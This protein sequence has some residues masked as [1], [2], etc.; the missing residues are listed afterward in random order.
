MKKNRLFKINAII[1]LALLLPSVVFGAQS[2][3]TDIIG[4]IQGI[5]NA[6]F[7]Y[8]WGLLFW[9]FSLGLLNI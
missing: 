5:V 9:D 7:P 8:F 1:G 6:L 4:P 2:I 3:E